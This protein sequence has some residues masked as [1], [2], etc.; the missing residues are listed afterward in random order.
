MKCL[1]YPLLA[2]LLFAACSKEDDSQ[3]VNT[4]EETNATASDNIPLNDLGTRLFKDSMGGLYPGGV[5]KPFGTYANDL[6]TTSNSIVPID[7]N[8]IVS[9]SSGSIVFISLGASTGGK[10]MTALIDKTKG[11]PLTNP[12][13]KLF[14][15]NQ[16]AQAAP[17]NFIMDPKSIYWNHV[18]QVLTRHKSSYKQVQVVYLETDDS[19]ATTKFPQRPNRVKNDIEASLRTMKQKFPNLKVVYVLGRTRTFSN[20]VYPWNTEPSPYY[21][22]WAC[23]WAIQDQI[24]GIPGTQY[25]GRNAVAP[26]ITWG[27]YQWATDAPRTTDGFSWRESDTKDGLHA[28]PAGQDILSGRFQ[29]FLLTDRNASLWYAKH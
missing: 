1:I 17:L 4:G 21:F 3:M 8:G 6:F 28:T 16:A 24:N 29:K 25:K 20:T 7:A 18:T 10:N 19:V 22:G 13:L 14:N 15:R 9:S 12:K 27:F 2:A 5:N 11:N 23:K 26:M